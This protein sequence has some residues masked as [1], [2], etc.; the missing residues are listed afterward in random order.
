[1]EPYYL[2]LKIGHLVGMAS[3]FGVALAIS[4][5]LSKKDKNDYDVILDLSTKVEI[6]ASFFMPLTGVLMMIENTDLLRVGWLHVK[7]IIS[8]FAVLFTFL[9]RSQL[10]HSDLDNVEI[11]NKFVFYRNMSLSLLFVII[12]FV[13]Y[14]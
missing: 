1:M 6:P 12:I 2:I 11:F 8:L 9:S 3:W 4:I 5:I 14:K 7:I 13:G 10:I